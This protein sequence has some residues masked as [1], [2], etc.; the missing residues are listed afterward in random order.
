M[1]PR[2]LIALAVFLGSYLPLSMI[3]L[4]QDFNI[5]LWGNPICNP[6]ID[7]GGCSTPFRN[8]YISVTFF[9]VCFLGLV[10]TKYALKLI[11]STERKIDIKEIKHTPTDLMNYVLPY[12]VSFMS[13]DYKEINKFLGFI[14]F[15]CWLFW[16]TYRS[17]QIILNPILIV[18]NWK[19]YEVKYTH[20][21]STDEMVGKILS[22][23]LIEVNLS[24][25]Y[26]E[27]QDVIIIKESDV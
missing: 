16:I 4:I 22:N 6:I 25:N 18:M 24:Y 5:D 14:V 23:T 20:S 2:L 27:I 21:G 7:F 13:V 9:C 15:L 3:L 10:I 19:L 8:S 11:K 26:Q 1:Q 12:V 17:G